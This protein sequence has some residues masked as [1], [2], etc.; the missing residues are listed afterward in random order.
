L[1]LL[2]GERRIKLLIPYVLLFPTLL[3]LLFSSVLQVNFLPGM[4]GNWLG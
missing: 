4:V 2:W 3:Y 1:P